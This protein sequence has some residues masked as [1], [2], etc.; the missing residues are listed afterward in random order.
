MKKRIIALALSLVML[1]GCLGMGVD[2]L[3]DTA[4][5]YDRLIAAQTAEEFDAIAES[6]TEEELSALTEA[7][8]VEI[9]NRYAAILGEDAAEPITYASSSV[10]NVGP[11]VKKDAVQTKARLAKAKAA[12]SQQDTSEPSKDEG[13]ILDKYATKNDD[14]TY[15]LTLESFV[16]GE[17]KITQEK[18]PADI[19]LV[20][21]VSGSMID[22]DE[23]I[24]LA[25]VSKSEGAE[26]LAKI[27]AILDEAK[28]YLGADAKY[29]WD[30]C[31]VKWGRPT[32]IWGREDTDKPMQ[33]VY[34][35]TF[36]A[37]WKTLDEG[38]SVSGKWDFNFY[39]SKLNAMKIATMKFV[40]QVAKKAN[41]DKVDHTISIVKFAGNDNGN[42]GNEN[43][44]YSY[45]TYH[46]Y[47]QTVL[48]PTS[49][50]NADYIKNTINELSAGGATRAD[51]GM[52]HAENIIN[53]IKRQSNKV[54]VM[55]T[56]GVPTSGSEFE[57]EVANDA[58][59]ASNG[60]KQNG[61]TVY[62]IG[63]FKAGTASDERLDKQNDPTRVSKYMHYV[64]SNF[65]YAKDMNTP[66][67]ATYPD[68]LDENGKPK[69]YF[70]LADSASRMKEI[71]DKISEE[72]SG[73]AKLDLGTET[74]LRD[75]VTDDFDI[76]AP[77]GIADIKVY[78]AD[79]IKRGA[80]RERVF[81]ERGSDG[82]KEYD[83]D[84]KIKYGNT[85]EVTGF[86]YSSKDNC[87]KDTIKNG[88]PTYSGKKL[89][90]EFNIKVSDSCLGGGWFDTN[91]NA[92]AIYDKG[93]NLVGAFPVPNVNVP[94][95]VFDLTVKKSAEDGKT[96][97]PKQTF[98]F[99]VVGT[100]DQTKRVNTKVVINGTGE[101]TLKDLPVGN[102]TITEDTGW[103]WRYTPDRASQTVNADSTTPQQTVTF[104]NELTNDSWLSFLNRVTNVFEILNAS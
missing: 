91:T 15:K 6:A 69:S 86:D 90:V 65:K 28:S 43:Y 34:D 42:I 51:Y 73:G 23:D 41:D 4:P 53:G 63:V 40:D 58:I 74:V 76:V 97:D 46:N 50:S 18:L 67:T 93:N 17:V 10:N 49:I 26:G 92:S 33:W 25:H 1:L 19:V 47:S 102:Y 14:G 7:Q 39:M 96:I 2:A 21:D 78:T 61:T 27:R 81:A 35:E 104:V 52:Q 83:A 85:V 12:A 29:R 32:D 9:S 87:V 37:R 66:G 94:R 8:L 72:V 44:F 59:D 24:L 64:S 84:V 89:I 11:L 95:K 99:N 54:V 30:D 60:M 103:S 57:Y 5:L 22:K 55:F 62:T 100:D 48:E 56:D 75:I 79:Y 3:T 31:E 80:D 13:L 88:V 71:F 101:V 77:N 38:I 16:T 68:G 82:W 45:K 70:L 20:L 36:T 98:I